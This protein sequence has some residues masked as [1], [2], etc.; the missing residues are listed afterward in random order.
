[1]I[2]L[3]AIILGIALVPAVRGTFGVLRRANLQAAVLIPFAL[4]LQTLSA[5]DGF[6][7][8]AA[9]PEL[10]SV[11]LW[12]AGAVLLAA[13]CWRNRRLHGMRIIALGLCMNALVIVAN[14]GMPVG[15]IALAELDAADAAREAVERSALYQMQEETTHLIVLADV[16]PVPGPTLLR[17][18]VSLGDLLL[19]VGIVVTIVESST[20]YHAPRGRL[21]G[22]EGTAGTREMRMG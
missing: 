18:V 8:G 2:P 14:V 22:H 4:L 20:R 13:V 12:I 7:W 16:L 5:S 6:L 1:L 10:L 21:T 15:L 9:N 3:L 11:G 19:F 17:A